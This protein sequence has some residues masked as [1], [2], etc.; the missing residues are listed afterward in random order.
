[1]SE[2]WIAY[3]RLNENDESETVFC[4]GEDLENTLKPYEIADKLNKLEAE[5]D[6]LNEQRSMWKKAYRNTEAEHAALKRENETIR[7]EYKVLRE[8]V[9]Q[10]VEKIYDEDDP[11]VAKPWLVE[12][13]LGLLVEALAVDALLTAEE[14]E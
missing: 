1:M 14:P 4:R 3:H 7:G 2:P 5:L 6:E 11:D 8:T 9:Q 13:V 12:N 10:A